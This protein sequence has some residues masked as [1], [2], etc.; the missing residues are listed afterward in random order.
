[1]S[2][3]KTSDSQDGDFKSANSNSNASDTSVNV[4]KTN[5]S[6]QEVF[7]VSVKIPPFWPDEPSIWFAQIEGQFSN[8]GITVDTTKFNY[9]IGELDQKYL[10]E[11]RDIIVKPPET[12]KYEKL[13]Q[14]LIKRL[15]ASKERKLQQLLMHEELGDRKPSQF[16]R[17]LQSLAGPDVSDDLLTTIWTSRLPKEY[18]TMIAGHPDTSLESLSE[19]TDKLHVIVSPSPCVASSSSSSGASTF[20]LESLQKEIAEMRR[21]MKRLAATHQSRSSSRGRPRSRSSSR[22]SST[23]SN[24]SYRK[25]PVCWYHARYGSDAAKCVKPCDYKSG[26]ATGGH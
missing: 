12:G 6:D 1:M 16:L 17:H 25:Y 21:E 24:S 8:A 18:Q 15:S 5:K 11:V 7:R 3:D 19:L 22:R 23:R 14:E 2:E 10:R 4:N 13:K 9:V 26:N 20:M